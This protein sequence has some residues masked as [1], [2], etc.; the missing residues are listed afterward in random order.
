M[1]RFSEAPEATQIKLPYGQSDE[2]RRVTAALE[3]MQQ[4][5][6]QALR[7]RKRLAD[8][9]EAVA[10]ISHD[11]RN[12][13]SAAQILSDGLADSKDPDVRDAAPRLERAIQ[14]SITLA[15]ATLKYG[16]S[17]TPLPSMQRESFK[18]AIDE[19]M[20][21]GIAG[22]PGVTVRVDCDESLA[23]MA[24]SDHL[25]RIITNLV[26]NAAK[27]ITSRPAGSDAGLVTA[28][29]SRSASGDTVVLVISDNGPGI[30][31]SVIAK[32]FQPFSKAGSDGGTGLGLAIA[33]ELA[34]G[35][36]GELSLV[37]SGPDGTSFSL[38][39]RAG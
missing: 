29:A 38:S 20:A 9:G 26:R 36:G 18:P 33:R 22:W 34:R 21:E 25:H 12:S 5:V 2:I 32:L 19:A 39:L 28:E 13:L 14:R 17:E 1:T 37:S 15:E 35:M 24:D 10:K 8:L 30:P 3:T 27:A 31:K 23:V 16:R 4:T 7:Q 11:L 6:S